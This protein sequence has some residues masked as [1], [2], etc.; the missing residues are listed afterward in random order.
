MTG[1]YGDVSM[2]EQC[3]FIDAADLGHTLFVKV[4]T[5]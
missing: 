5:R 4:G 3:P 1:V 2:M